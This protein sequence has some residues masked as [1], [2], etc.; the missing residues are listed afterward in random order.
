LEVEKRA[1]EKGFIVSRP[2]IEVRYDLVID[3][4]KNLNRV[5]VKYTAQREAGALNIGLRKFG[6]NKEVGLR[7]ADV[8]TYSADEVDVLAVFSPVSGKVY[9]VPIEVFEGKTVLRLRLEP[10]KN[11]QKK[12]VL[13][14]SEYEL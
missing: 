7:M 2:V 11:N 9:W 12:R 6:G 8:K 14:A 3:D 13:M 1:T 10:S 4:G 5:Q